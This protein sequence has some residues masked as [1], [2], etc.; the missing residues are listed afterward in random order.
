[1]MRFWANLLGYQ[2]VWFAAVIGAARGL[3][4]PAVL[5]AGL[6]VGAQWWA[7]T[8]RRSDALLVAAALGLGLLVDG[9]LGASG[10]VMYTAAWPW[11]FVAPAWILALWAAF[12]MTFNH[13][14]GFLQGRP[15]W[16]AVLGA[17]GGPLA[18]FG[19]ERAFGAI[20]L[21]HPLALPLGALA[22]AWA[23]STALLVALAGCGR[24]SAG[25]RT[26]VIQHNGV[27][28]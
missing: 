14:L 26:R 23:I 11:P 27:G 3:I 24:R 9:S 28:S 25:L 17:F 13:S 22:L 15:G 1:M 5:A 20:H 21:M 2:L 4:W 12:A 10:W 16:A 18:Y 19:A 6:F 8:K 7:S